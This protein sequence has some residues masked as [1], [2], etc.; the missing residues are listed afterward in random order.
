[1]VFTKISS[2]FKTQWK[3]LRDA[4]DNE[5]HERRVQQRQEKRRSKQQRKAA[6]RAAREARRARRKQRHTQHLQAVVG[7]ALDDKERSIPSFG[8]R[9]K[10]LEVLAVPLD[11]ASSSE[12]TKVAVGNE[13]SEPSVGQQDVSRPLQIASPL[14]IA[15]K[16]AVADTTV[17]TEAKAKE[18]LPQLPMELA[19]RKFYDSLGGYSTVDEEDDEILPVFLGSCR[20]TCDSKLPTN[21][22]A[23]DIKRAVA[24]TQNLESVAYKALKEEET[25]DANDLVSLEVLPPPALQR[26]PS[27]LFK[28]SE[29][30]EMGPEDEMIDQH[31]SGMFDSYN[32]VE[33]ESQGQFCS[34]SELNGAVNENK[35]EA[36]VK[37]SIQ[38]NLNE[39]ML[40]RM[41]TV[42]GAL[43]TIEPPRILEILDEN[44]QKIASPWFSK[45]KLFDDNSFKTESDRVLECL[46]VVYEVKIELTKV[47]EDANTLDQ[48]EIN[49][50]KESL[51]SAHEVMPVQN[52]STSDSYSSLIRPHTSLPET[53]CLGTVDEYGG[54]IYQSLRARE[55]RYHVTEDIFAKQQSVRPRMR[56][57][58]VDWLI[59][60]HQRFELEAQTL[61]LT[62][63]YV[64]RYLAQESVIP[65]RF[66]LVGVAALLIASKFEE[67]YP[68]DMNDLLYICERSY[69]KTDLIDCER[70]LLNVFKFN[71]AVP[72][73]STFLGFYLEHFD[74]DDKIIEQLANYFA[75]CSLLDFTFSATYEP[76]IVACAC[77][78][79]A[80]CY[81]ENQSPSLVWNYRLVEITGYAV[82]AIV[83]CTQDLSSI[84]IQPTELTAVATKYSG[85]EFGKVAD[86]LL[87]DLEGLLC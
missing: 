18:D 79:A 68:C 57:V 44:V 71:L 19:Q 25:I 15:T 63:N 23:V 86:L 17:T 72:S 32:N 37:N 20:Y 77:L 69:S 52:S 24:F 9:G 31:G 10:L 4:F 66:Q 14:C 41:S 67:I 83:P 51:Y 62:V 29:V 53:Y 8:P 50:K 27:S 34:T 22:K 30:V 59:E 46:D 55:H 36:V 48:D 74:E 1:M 82:E 73:V 75:E 87:D 11:L 26:R 78:L 3:L 40:L 58:L 7:E 39:E 35:E 65:Q 5:N 45:D 6:R 43:K 42:L 70:D 16:S 64:D 54:S 56:A 21:Y 12:L 47:S 76:S 84:L 28:C 49:A 61:F 85:N 2:L 81:V 13:S 80:N 60:V 33:K 38:T